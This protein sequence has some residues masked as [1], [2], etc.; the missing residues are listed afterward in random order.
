MTFPWDGADNKYQ[1]L[2][3]TKKE[4][5]AGSSTNKFPQPN[6]LDKESFD[7]L[8]RIDKEKQNFFSNNSSQII[9]NNSSIPVKMYP[10]DTEQYQIPASQ[11]SKR[12]MVLDEKTRKRQNDLL[13]AS[14]QPN[15]KSD[16]GG[17]DLNNYIKNNDNDE[18]FMRQPSEYNPRS[19]LNSRSMVE[20]PGNSYGSDLKKQ[21]LLINLLLRKMIKN[22]I[23]YN[24]RSREKNRKI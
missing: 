12:D 16:N 15:M 13:S 14:Y 9:N 6:S 19:I 17:L 20:K 1:T 11:R 5:Y 3:Q 2:L 4:L 24:P 23:D 22:S 21:V 8:V 10:V 18:S 7:K